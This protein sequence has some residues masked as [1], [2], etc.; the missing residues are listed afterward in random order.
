MLVARN[1]I[2]A[3]TGLDERAF[4]RFEKKAVVTPWLVKSGDSV[5]KVIPGET[6]YPRAT[7]DEIALGKFYANQDE[8]LADNPGARLAA[9]A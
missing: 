7:A 3:A 2:R 8:Y 1:D 5:V 9:A 6:S 4:D